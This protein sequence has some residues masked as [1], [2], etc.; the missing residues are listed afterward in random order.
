MNKFKLS[1]VAICC[2]F[3]LQVHAFNEDEQKLIKGIESDAYQLMAKSYSDYAVYFNL[4]QKQPTHK[5]CEQEYK[6]A[7]HAYRVSKAN[8]DV[9]EML[10][11]QDMLT[12]PLPEGAKHELFSALK[13]L[14]YVDDKQTLNEQS[15]LA[16]VNRWGEAHDFQKT[17][18]IYLL[19]LVMVNTELLDK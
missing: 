16:A 8:Y 13:V 9:L 11:K 10:K 18:E 14:G 2:A 7:M 1:I 12:L 4:C 6:G 15:L 5:K 17:D 3:T 19:H